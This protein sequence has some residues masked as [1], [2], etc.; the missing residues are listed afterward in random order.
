VLLISHCP[1]WGFYFASE[2]E[3]TH[4]EEVFIMERR[5]MKSLL[6][7]MFL[8]G[9]LLP[10]SLW[11]QM[12]QVSRSS[13]TGHVKDSSGAVI[14]GATVT[15]MEQNTGLKFTTQ[16]EVDGEYLVSELLAG[17]YSVSAEAK[18]FKR[19]TVTGL[20]LD[21]AR[22]LTQDLTLEVGATTQSVTVTGKASL[23]ETS[24]NAVSAT[25]DQQ[26]LLELPIP[27]RNTY[28]FVNLVPTVVWNT[29]GQESGPGSNA[30]DIATT[31]DGI[32]NGSDNS[33]Q[34][35]A[36]GVEIQTPPDWLQEFQV[37][38]NNTSAQY[39][40]DAS[41]NFNAVT[42]GGTNQFHGDVYEF[43]RNQLFDAAGWGAA[44]GVKPELRQNVPGG[45]IGGPIR[46]DKTFFFF[47]YQ[48][49]SLNQSPSAVSAGNVGLPAWRTGD[50]S[51]ATASQK[52]NGVTS[53]AVVPIYDPA[54]GETTQIS[55]NGVLNVICP[56][57][58][59][60][61]AQA[62][63]KF[64]PQPNYG[65]LTPANN[66]GNFYVTP[67]AT[68]RRPDYIGR[69]D[70][71]LGQNTKMY[72]RY[73]FN[74]V[75]V[76][77][78][79]TGTSSPNYGP[80]STAQHNIYTDQ[81]IALNLTHVFS[82]TFFMD[83]TIGVARQY[84]IV[85][86][87]GYPSST[88]WPVT[89]GLGQQPV[90]S[91]PTFDIGGGLIPVDNFGGN[92]YRWQAL[93]YSNYPLNFTK[94]KGTHTIKFGISVVKFSFGS[95]S[96]GAAGTYLFNG[97]YTECATGSCPAGYAPSN[98]GIYMA[99][100]ELGYF[101]SL[102]DAITPSIGMHQGIY[103]GYIQDDW[104]VTHNLTLNVGLRYET[105][106]PP[107]GT[108]NR[109][110]SF[111]PYLPNPLAGTGSG[112]TAI[113]AGQLGITTFENLNGQGKYLWNW[114]TKDLVPRVGFAYRV[115]GKSDFVIRG[116]FGIYLTDST[117]YGVSAGLGWGGSYNP[118][119]SPASPSPVL[120]PNA[121]PAGALNTPPLSALTST[122]GDVGTAYPQGSINFGYPNRATPYAMQFNFTVQRQWKGMFFEVG[123]V[124]NLERHASGSNYNVNLIP[125]N[126]L[127]AASLA[128]PRLL[129]PFTQ[130]SGT[131]A[132]VTSYEDN[133]ATVDYHAM[134]LKAER[135]WSSG[136]SYIAA[137]T[138]SKWI[139]DVN[140]NGANFSDIYNRK[141]EQSLSGYDVPWRLVFSPIAELPFGA[142]K[143]WLNQG[144]VVNQLVGGWE[145]SA[146]GTYQSGY[147]QSFSVSGGTADLGDTSYNALRP[148]VLAGCNPKSSSAWQP[149]PNGTLGFQYVN[150]ACFIGPSNAAGSI[151]P[152]Y[153]FGNSSRYLGN[154]FGPGT[155]QF[156]F[157]LSKN[158]YYKER[159]R[160]QIRM[161]A[162]DLFNTTSF[163]NPA[164]TLNGSN[165]G[166]V[167]GINNFANAANIAGTPIRRMIDL[168][169]KLY[170]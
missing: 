49:L 89:L 128:A 10:A 93:T 90:N 123:Y 38:T 94:V 41:G 92:L 139:D 110:Q 13:I 2:I 135:R 11:G 21:A 87:I 19:L 31:I 39:G 32:A 67:V 101:S 60:S 27:D 133:Q 1:F 152:Y 37:S 43:V 166:L 106:T 63:L 44:H 168:G 119:F 12:G 111:N 159:Y 45:T 164:T 144:G 6:A 95:A 108:N 88:N 46:K 154:L 28:Y 58:L 163:G 145:M 53:V 14:A 148:D 167:T 16:T 116:G 18:G 120:G 86:A 141:G 30:Y 65:P 97:T 155:A 59:N 104:R 165:F 149:A 20:Q 78:W 66:G 131:N 96:L 68:D 130:F 102:Q 138:W 69:V 109:F 35:Q 64:I 98:T 74:K 118:S 23:V 15:I 34:A 85:A 140:I 153:T 71:A 105:I 121:V 76:F 132:S 42:K 82:P 162:Y 3:V 72:V 113:N 156:N 62:V 36:D 26:H 7:L 33:E 122:F 50:F 52:I 77:S 150:T 91:F 125:P 81:N 22:T 56:A 129:R 29:T 80:A 99:D 170:F 115:G 100:M 79:S 142:G 8:L 137:F 84:R 124:G 117:P 17:V 157:M 151:F 75:N 5:S 70:E 40:N 126:L 161:E 114:D 48:W 103:A 146:L 9:L 51:T 147:P 143:H 47:G 160:L 134:T 158:F 25:V 169:A 4:T 61:V 24:T 73:I 112:S 57:R 136:F 127:S 54:T 55:C 83:G 107:H